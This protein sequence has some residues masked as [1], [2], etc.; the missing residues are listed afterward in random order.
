MDKGSAAAAAGGGRKEEKG[1]MG[2]KE[3]CAKKEKEDGRR[4]DVLRCIDSKSQP[5]IWNH[6][7][8]ATSCNT[9]TIPPTTKPPPTL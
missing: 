2:G 6:T 9:P 1:N 4:I 8:T 7:H 3:G 5:L